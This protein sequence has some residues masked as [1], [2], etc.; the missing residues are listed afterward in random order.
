M[1]RILACLCT[2]LASTRLAAEPALG[3]GSVVTGAKLGQVMLGLLGIL[4]LI[5]V[6]AWLARVVFRIQPASNGSLRIIAG[7]SMGAREKIVLLQVG[8]QQLVLGVAPGRI[9][10]LHVLDEPLPVETGPARDPGRGFAGVLERY[11]RGPQ[12]GDMRS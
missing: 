9:T 4:V 5:L 10:T 2:A 11:R 3:A 8:G 7:L 12:A 1:S 6:F